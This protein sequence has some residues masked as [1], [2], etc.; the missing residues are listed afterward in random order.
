MPAMDG[1]TLAMKIKNDE[2]LKSL[3]IVLHT[4]ITGVFNKE[5]V[6]SVG[7]D[8]FIC[9]FD[10]NELSKSIIKNLKV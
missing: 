6:D 5:L 2:K 4:S 8:D 10:P 7:A 1:Y 9:K 3:K